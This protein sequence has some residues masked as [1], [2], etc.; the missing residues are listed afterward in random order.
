MDHTNDALTIIHSV[1][2]QSEW[3]KKLF[4]Y[5]SDLHP[6]Q[7][8][9]CFGQSI[10][11]IRSAIK[12]KVKELITPD[13]DI[14]APLLIA[15]DTGDSFEISCWMFEALL[16]CW[17]G[18]IFVVLGNHEL[19]DLGHDESQ[20]IDGIIN[21][22]R[23]FAARQPRLHILENELIIKMHNS[24]FKLISEKELLAMD[25]TE[26]W[27]RNG[28]SQY[29]ILGGIGF[30]GM[31]PVLNAET[32]VYQGKLTGEEDTAR[33]F[34]F[35]KIH[36]RLRLCAGS[37][38]V[39][40]LTHTPPQDWCTGIR[41]PN[42]VY[43]CG[44]NHRNSFDCPQNGPVILNDNQMG[45]T[46]CKWGVKAF[47]FNQDHE[48]D[49]LAYLPDGIHQI[50]SYEYI[51]YLRSSG[52]GIQSFSRKGTIWVIKHDSTY[53]FL[54]EGKKLYILN[55]GS[56]RVAGHTLSYYDEHLAWYIS[57][58]RKAFSRYDIEKKRLGEE[59]RRLGGWGTD[60]GCI[61]DID[62]WNHIYCDP[63]DGKINFYYA[64]DIVNKTFYQDFLHLIR[65]SPS[66]PCRETIIR[67]LEAGCNVPALLPAVN[68]DA[69]ISVM[70]EFIQDT[71]MYDTSRKMRS[72]QYALENK[73]IRFW[74]D[75]IL[76][77]DFDDL[78]NNRDNRLLYD[79]KR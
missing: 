71:S 20:S 34:R 18:E 12:R 67:R 55:G 61:V 41:C 33:S 17:E 42:W 24:E 25:P 48:Y 58:I 10:S 54:L 50:S 6:E 19:W 28:F 66:L 47:T 45:F 16:S 35:S 57:Q 13:V 75:A 26:F 36:E 3:N 22:Y 56:I 60:H 59:I 30:S 63:R 32:G 76:D 2:L 64:T 70:P 11:D 27:K 77:Y 14:K 52:I 46:P 40:V 73:V 53:M 4:Y 9:A 44:H 51:N 37:N 7:Q 1:S 21:E 69:L 8:L 68:E 79:H 5:I 38:R 43:V 74:Q 72:V 29:M 49:P 15:G 23:A 65:E 31:N 39:V 78:Q 62:F